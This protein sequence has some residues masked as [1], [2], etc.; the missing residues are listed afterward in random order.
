MFYYWLNKNKLRER[1]VMEY[2]AI[3]TVL[4][5]LQYFYFGMASGMARGKAGLQAPAITGDELYER[6]YRIH[7]NTMEQLVSFLPA[8]WMFS[9]YVSPIYGA[10]LGVAFLV[11]RAIYSASYA[12]DPATRGKGFAIGFFAMLIGFAGTLY[13]AVISFL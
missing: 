3:V 9:H 7:Q 8:M 12:K 10:G 1:L 13:G 2:V 5:L 4:I 6:K 11:G